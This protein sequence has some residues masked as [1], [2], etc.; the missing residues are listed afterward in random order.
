MLVELKGTLKVIMAE[1]KISDKLSKKE[2]VITIDEDTQYPQDVICQAVNK[3]IE[4]LD[5][6]AF[7]MGAQVVAS[8]EL[9]GRE[10][11]GKYYNNFQLIGISIK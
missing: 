10:S 4:L 8:C 11:K 6:P 3:K 1:Q 9:R 5:D 7:A 2:I